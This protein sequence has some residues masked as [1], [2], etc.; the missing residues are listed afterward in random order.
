MVEWP[1]ECLL[2]LIAIDFASVL[3]RFRCNCSAQVFRCF[4]TSFFLRVCVC[5]I[6]TEPAIATGPKR[7]YIVKYQR[8]D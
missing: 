7:C 5:I 6:M 1:L 2:I 4:S 8:D 3:V